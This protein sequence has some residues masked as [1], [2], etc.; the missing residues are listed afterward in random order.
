MR[1]VTGEVPDKGALPSGA[2]NPEPYRSN[3][4]VG[5][6]PLWARNSRNRYGNIRAK[7]PAGTPGHFGGTL[8]TDRTM[9]FE[10]SPADPKD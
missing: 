1:T 4:L 8:P 3:R 5:S 7:N 6:S 2:R 10:K 9:G